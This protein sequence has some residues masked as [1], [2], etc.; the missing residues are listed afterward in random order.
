IGTYEDELTISLNGVQISEVALTLVVTPVN[1]TVTPNDRI[2]FEMQWGENV[3]NHEAELIVTNLST[4]MNVNV[5]DIVRQIVGDEFVVETDAVTLAPNGTI[6]LI[7][8]P[9]G[10]TGDDGITRVLNELGE[11]ENLLQISYA[12][13]NVSH[14]IVLKLT[15]HPPG[16]IIVPD[17]GDALEFELYVSENAETSDYGTH[18]LTIRNSG[19]GLLDLSNISFAF[20]NTTSNGDNGTDNGSNGSDNGAHGYAPVGELSGTDYGTDTLNSS[21]SFFKAGELEGILSPGEEVIF[22]VSVSRTPVASEI[23]THTAILTITNYDQLVGTVDLVL[24]VLPI[25]I[26]AEW[27]NNNDS[28]TVLANA[29]ASANR[30]VLVVN[31]ESTRVALELSE[32]LLTLSGIN[33]NQ[34]AFEALER[35]GLLEALGSREIMF[36]P[37]SNDNGRIPFS[38]GRF[39]N[40]LRVTHNFGGDNKLMQ[41]TLVV[42]GQIERPQ[43][44]TSFTMQNFTLNQGNR[45]NQQ[46]SASG[47]ATGAITITNRG[48]LPSWVNLTTSGGNLRAQVTSRAPESFPAS[49]HRINIRRGNVTITVTISITARRVD[50][51]IEDPRRRLVGDVDLDG[52]ITISDA[53]Q[54]L[55]FL[56]DLSSTIDPDPERDYVLARLNAQT[57]DAENATAD[58]MVTIA[59]A[60]QVL[61]YL[62]NLPTIEGGVGSYVYGHW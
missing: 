54:I 38:A 27:L 59:D 44:P 37:I 21:D 28:I 52:S 60:L 1:F 58:G 3:R 55:R 43:P 30:L 26:T 45:W 36:Q 7:V 25:I 11:Y 49:S 61:R 15:V 29:V 10:I 13:G 50:G 12:N 20:T 51:G 35:E 22:P 23:G 33:G 8:L 5:S 6:T 56:V 53:L 47:N 4:R 42:Q 14:E 48:N 40:E 2:E 41:L 9:R 31:N 18:Y 46:R 24:E 39:E 34:I 17:F 16:A 57:T 19:E 32:L 62:V